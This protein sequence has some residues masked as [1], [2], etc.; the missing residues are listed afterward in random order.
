MRQAL[1]RQLSLSIGLLLLIIGIAS[2]L[3]RQ[4]Q[5]EPE[6]WTSLLG[7]L[8]VGDIIELEIQGAD[9]SL[10]IE[11]TAAGWSTP[12]QELSTDQ[13]QAAEDLVSLLVHAQRGPDLGAVD[14]SELGLYPPDR[15]LVIT[16]SSGA[17]V[18]LQ[19][20]D[21]TPDQMHDYLELDSQI[22]ISR[23]RLSLS[24]DSLQEHMLNSQES[25]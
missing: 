21:P 25:P 7:A 2:W 4:P 18:H 12:S 15:T 5:G 11:R 3:T 19:M 8:N 20:G 23:T 24:V 1:S 9:Q 10:K 16:T 13:I 22:S 6:A 17:V 14:R